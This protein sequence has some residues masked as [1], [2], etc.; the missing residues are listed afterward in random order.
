MLGVNYPSGPG[1]VLSA[2]SDE[3]GLSLFDKVGNRRALLQMVT[4]TSPKGP[5]LQ[6]LDADG[7]QLSRA[8]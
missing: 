8:P 2:T 6:L 4:L 7:K 3:P 1:A 5:T